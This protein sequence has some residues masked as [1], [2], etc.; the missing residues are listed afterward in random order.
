MMNNDLQIG[1]SVVIVAYNSSSDIRECVSSIYEYNDI[2]D[3]LEVVVVDNC[4]SDYE[5]THSIL[6]NNFPKVKILSNKK[7]GGYGQGNNIGIAEATNPIVLIM[8]PDVRLFKP[9]FKKAIGHYNSTPRLLLLGM[10]Q[11]NTKELKGS[12]FSMKKPSYG[13]LVIYKIFSFL[14]IYN[15]KYFFISGACHFIKKDE[16]VKIGGYDEN[17]FLYGEETDINERILAN[18]YKISFDKSIG[19]IHPMHERGDALITL[20]R[21]L[22]SALYISEKNGWSKV[23]LLK[24]YCQ[25]FQ[26]LLFR[27]KLRKDIKQGE[28]YR[29]FLIMLKEARQTV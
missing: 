21:G 2:E 13:S 8:N 26:F 9:I 10:Q 6:V 1:V 27:S 3:K 22:K 16:F 4:S 20:Q 12:S 14:N 5:E 19:Y 7:N 18:N 25:Y 17:I 28:I 11:Y 23:K 29:K 24:G 15:P